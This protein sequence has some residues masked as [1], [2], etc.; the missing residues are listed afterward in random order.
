MYVLY[1]HTVPVHGTKYRRMA[2]SLSPGVQ[3]VRDGE[4]TNSKNATC[5]ILFVFPTSPTALEVTCVRQNRRLL[6]L[7]NEKE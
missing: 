4:W 6:T 1:V 5:E 3:K 2:H 7:S